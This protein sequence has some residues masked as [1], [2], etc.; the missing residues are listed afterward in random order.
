M[1]DNNALYLYKCILVHE[2][3]IE[4]FLNLLERGF[5]D[6]LRR[7][8][9]FNSKSGYTIRDFLDRYRVSKK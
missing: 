4:E 6:A 7:V 8:G 2:L 5:F 3:T 9:C 1:K